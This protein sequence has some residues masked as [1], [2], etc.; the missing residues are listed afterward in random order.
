LSLRARS[1]WGT[2]SILQERRSRLRLTSGEEVR[3]G[4]LAADALAY[5]WKGDVRAGGVP[6]ATGSSAIVEHGA[7][8]ELAGGETEAE[9]LLFAGGGPVSHGRPGGKVHLLPAGRVPGA[10]A[11]A[12]SEGIGGWMHSDGSC[13]GCEVWLHENRFAPGP[14]EPEALAPG[15]QPR[16][17]HS[18]SESELIFVTA[19]SIRLGHRLYPAGTAVAI[20]AD[21]MYHLGPGPEG[22]TFVNFRA[23]TPSDIRFANGHRISETGYWRE[24][25]ARP[26]YLEPA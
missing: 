1:G 26:E 17:L 20:A 6:L 13:P 23:G 3:V 15:E 11:L 25:V 2:D 7:A 19:G 24:R 4:P 16:G 10:D 14:A 18:H 8:L 5:V 9:V 12:G 21:T 22:M